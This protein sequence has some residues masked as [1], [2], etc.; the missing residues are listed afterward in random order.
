[1]KPRFVGTDRI[2]VKICGVTSESDALAACEAGADA[3]G[4]NF[5]PNSKRYIEPEY[6]GQWGRQ[7]PES[8]ERVGVFV[9]AEPRE[10]F[11]LLEAGVIHAA[12]FHG[13]ET[14]EY[15]Q[16]YSGDF[17][18]LKA[19]TVKDDHSLAEISKFPAKSILLDAYCKATYGGSGTSFDWSLARRFVVENPDRHVVL[20]GGLRPDNVAIAAGRV[21]PAAVDVASGVELAP[22]I[23]DCSKVNDFIA[24]VREV[25]IPD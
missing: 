1:M 15:Y 13:N 16:R 23:K 20:A 14:V 11:G 7:L 18:T 6:F 21:L 2:A 24:A 8:T 3:L 12:Q 5:W 4:F 19:F 10:V 22:G 17:R 25:K 9:N